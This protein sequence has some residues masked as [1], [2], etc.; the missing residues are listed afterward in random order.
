MENCLF[1]K[2]VKKEIPAKIVFE[3]EKVL[4]FEDINPAAPV[5]ILIV[6]KSHIGSLNELD[7][8]RTELL[9]PLFLA[10]K[11]IAAE[12]GIDKTGY[13]TVFNTGS[14]AGQTVFHLHLHLLGGRSFAWPPG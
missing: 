14:G 1:C 5:H 3:D 8:S 10:A 2:I 12:K 4:A 11:Q 13:R 9:K 6:P 7:E